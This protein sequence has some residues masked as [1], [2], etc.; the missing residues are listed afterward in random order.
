[1]F[2]YIFLLVAQL[3]LVV[4]SIVC[5]SLYIY[6]YKKKNL[7]K[8]SPKA[9]TTLPTY[10]DKLS[11]RFCRQSTVATRV[12]GQ[13]HMQLNIYIF[14]QYINITGARVCLKE[15]YESK[16]DPLSVSYT[17]LSGKKWWVSKGS[18]H[19]SL[20][21]RSTKKSKSRVKRY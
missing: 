13:K 10:L 6:I 20:A 19:Q 12:R 1:M 2:Y 15:L 11:E 18:G 4:C 14:F 9:H 17:V 8:V 3:F 7:I 21:G 5:Y 16:Y